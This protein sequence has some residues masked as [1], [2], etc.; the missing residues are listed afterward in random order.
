M[1][2]PVPCG[3]NHTRG[4]KG[5]KS[6]I[7]HVCM[8]NIWCWCTACIMVLLAVAKGYNASHYSF[9]SPHTKLIWSAVTDVARK[10]ASVH[11][12]VPHV[13]IET[14]IRVRTLICDFSSKYKWT[15][16][17]TR[18]SAYLDI[19]QDWALN[20]EHVGIS[21]QLDKN[22]P[23]YGKKK[24]LT[25]P[26]PWPWPDWSQNLIKW[27]PDNNQSSHQIPCDSRRLWPFSWPWPL[28]FD[29]IDPKIESNGPG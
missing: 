13:Q 20:Y 28:T 6:Y 2:W 22:W 14:L 21:C 24:I 27:S 10:L 4:F 1:R 11:R 15:R 23:R 9:W 25:Y 16:T 26:W 7:Q 5:S 8:H 12:T 3:S 19:S 18:E 17:G 29:P